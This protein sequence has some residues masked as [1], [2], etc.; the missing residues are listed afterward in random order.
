M[1][2]TLAII[3]LLL[4]MGVS[5]VAQSKGGQNK[6]TTKAQIVDTEDELTFTIPVVQPIPPGIRANLRVVTRFWN[7]WH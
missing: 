5:L 4:F 6:S 1:K 7:D 3:S 2:Q